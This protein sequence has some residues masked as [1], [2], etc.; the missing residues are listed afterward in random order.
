MWIFKQ[1][2]DGA[3]S[4]CLHDLI[5]S[6]QCLLDLSRSTRSK[7]VWQSALNFS[8]ERRANRVNESASSRKIP[9]QA[10]LCH[11]D[12]R[13]LI[14]PLSH[15]LFRTHIWTRRMWCWILKENY[16]SRQILHLMNQCCVERKSK[17]RFWIYSFNNLIGL[18]NN[19][20]KIF[21][22]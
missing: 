12:L 2:L 20:I 5:E 17:N 21:N 13:V 16:L 3:A 14:M 18:I 15:S 6:K 19:L 11:T 1:N 4:H 10:H 9:Y 7:T 8:P 22:S